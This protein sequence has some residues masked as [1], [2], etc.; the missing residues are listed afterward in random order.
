MPTKTPTQIA[1]DVVEA[2]D[3]IA[4]YLDL[5]FEQTAINISFFDQEKLDKINQAI[6]LRQEFAKADLVERGK[7]IGLNIKMV[8]K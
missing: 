8:T 2:I 7:M 3:T 4:T 5:T 6:N 1:I